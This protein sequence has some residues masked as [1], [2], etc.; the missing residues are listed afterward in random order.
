L[1]DGDILVSSSDIVGIKQEVP[2]DG[3]KEVE[4]MLWTDTELKM[5]DEKM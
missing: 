5:H 4:P 1:G 2:T 3:N